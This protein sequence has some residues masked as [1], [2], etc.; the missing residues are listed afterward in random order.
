MAKECFTLNDKALASR[1][2]TVAAK[3]MGYGYAIFGFAPYSPFWREM[4]KIVMFELLSNRRLDTLKHVQVSE[5]DIGIQE[6]YKL[7]VNNN[8][9]RPMLVELKRWFENLTL[10][11]IVRMVDGKRYFGVGAT[12]SDFIDVMLLLQ[13]D[14]RLSSFPYDAD[15]SIKSTCLALIL[16]GSDTT[17]GTLTW[18]ISLLLNKPKILTKAQEEIDLHAGKNRQVDGSDIPI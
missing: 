17:A 10:N 8:S 6:L 18:A 12:S 14:G 2:T 15:T 3:H 4:R 16:G 7:W 9:D 1:P 13:E 11:V 5:V